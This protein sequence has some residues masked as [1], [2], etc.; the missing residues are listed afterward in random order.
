MATK[1]ASWQNNAKS[2]WFYIALVILPTLQ[3]LLFWVYVNFNSIL[4]AFKVY[5]SD[6]TTDQEG[7]K[8]GLA[9]FKHWFTSASLGDTRAIR[10]NISDV[11]PAIWVSLKSYFLGLIVSVPLG[12]FFSYYMFKRMPGAG[13][14]RI[15]LFL[16]SILSAAPLALIFLNLTSAGLGGVDGWVPF[17]DF[18]NS[19]HMFTTSTVFSM[20]IGFGTSVLMYTNKM[21]SIDYEVI[22]SAH[23]DGANGI[24][25]FWYI[26]LPQS[27]SIVK[28]FLITSFAG[29]FSSQGNAYILFG[30][31]QNKEI[32]SVGYLLW[33][34]VRH[35]SSGD[36]IRFMAPYAAFG[37]IMTAIVAPLT[38][39]FRWA[40]NRF[41]WQDN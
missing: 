26:V 38:F 36:S 28:V 41:A 31:A 19:K 7:W 2:R 18:T 10:Y 37:L 29:A 30:T 35:S 5:A 12:L 4:L 27:F 20:F 39:L 40:L 32:T 6:A 23:L 13:L 22:E 21:D 9:N 8:W 34:G 25:E 3:F 15:M 33:N 16:P 14:F 24:K 17:L 11:A 1:K